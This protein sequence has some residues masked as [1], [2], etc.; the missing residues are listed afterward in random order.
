MVTRYVMAFRTRHA[1]RPRP[2]DSCRAILGLG[3]SIGD[4]PFLVSQLVRIAIGSVAMNAAYR[5]LGQGQPSDTALERLQ[6]LLLDEQAQPLLVHALRGE[7]A[8]MTEV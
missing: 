3:R 5:V 1:G 6:A 8:V 4:E 7:R 2:V